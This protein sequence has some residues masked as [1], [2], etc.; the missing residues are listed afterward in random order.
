[1]I[2]LITSTQELIKYRAQEKSS[3]GFVPTMGNLHKGHISLLEEA[4]KDADCVYFSIFVNPKQFGPSEDFQ[5]YPRTLEHDMKLLEQCIEGKKGKT[6][7]VYAP[8]PVTEVFPE[9]DTRVIS[10]SGLNKILEGKYRP[11]H[12]DGVATVVYRLFELVKPDKGFF[13]L[14]DYQQYLVIKQM[15]DDLK[16][17]VKIIGMPIIREPSGLAM[18][19]RNQYLFADQKEEALILLR[20]LKK[21]ES[22]IANKR[23][24]LDEAQK[25]IDSIT[26]DKKWNYLEMRDAA[27]LS[28]DISN[29]TELSIVAVYQIGN[30]RLLD[31][32]QVTIK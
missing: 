5:K 32:I 6:I 15:A 4:L 13:G 30:T 28:E 27:T 22:I 10:V 17:P 23:S 7:V 16:L 9:G 14:K 31:N 21:V 26:K 1:M 29:S 25:E 8:S 3:V 18:S 19:S 12:F 11:D 2:K 20:S 24:N